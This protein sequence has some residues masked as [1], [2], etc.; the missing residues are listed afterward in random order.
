[1]GER[2]SSELRVC[3]VRIYDA[4]IETLLAELEKPET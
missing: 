2:A 3:G 4:D 1:M